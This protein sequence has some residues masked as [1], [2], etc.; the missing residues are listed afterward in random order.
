[1]VD[2]PSPK[3]VKELRGF[4]GL[5]GYYRRFVANYGT[6]A[7]PLTQWLKKEGFGWSTEA[8]EAFQRLKS[9]MLTVP[10]LRLPDFTKVFVIES[11]ASGVG[12]GA[13]LM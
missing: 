13:V 3:N 8:E 9:A 12:V 11:D 5:I 10:V 1:M 4:L 2:W 6:Q 7:F